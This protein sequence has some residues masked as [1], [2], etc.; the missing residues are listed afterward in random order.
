MI[1]K[2]EKGY[3]VDVRP[4]GRN[5]KR[6][7]KTLATIA[8]ARAFEKHMIA[9]H[10]D[11]EE[12][13]QAKPDTRKLSELRNSWYD[14]HGKQLKSGGKRLTELDKIIDLLD[15]PIAAKFTAN[16]FTKVRATRIGKVSPNTVNHDLANLKALFNELIR[17]GDWTL[18]NPLANVRKMKHDETELTFLEHA[19]IKLLLDE[20]DKSPQSHARITARI[21]LATGARWGEA[22]TC[23]ASMVRNGKI[24][25]SG[26]KNGKNRT[27]PISKD[28][29]KLILDNAPLVCGMNTFKR[30]VAK[31]DLDLPKG[32]MTHVLRHT[33]A[34]HFMINGGNIL[35][36][37]RAL[38]HGDIKMTM[39]YSHLSPDH[40]NEVRELNPLAVGQ[41]SDT[42]KVST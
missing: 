26:T 9:K 30:A 7:R 35:A 20:L 12:W 6:F 15:D 31:L 29:E 27:L 14:L 1:K 36:L 40:L 10:K 38:G 18:P 42:P 32:Q 39:R 23:K 37:Q 2:V 4:A 24:T 41:K 22:A 3:L 11:T 16:D 8:E 17:L 21:C 13:Q 33:F 28:L 34:S 19:E 25:F 5:G